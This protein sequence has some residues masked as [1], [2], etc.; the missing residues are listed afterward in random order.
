MLKN[1]SKSNFNWSY[2][3]QKSSTLYK[4]T[5]ESLHKLTTYFVP[6]D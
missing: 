3:S 6:M 5:T 2:L 4:Q 1:R